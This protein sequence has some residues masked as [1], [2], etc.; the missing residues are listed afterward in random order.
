MFMPRCAALALL[1]C[2]VPEQLQATSIRADG[3]LKMHQITVRGTH[4]SY[5]L[6]PEGNVELRSLYVCQRPLDKQAEF[7]SVRS[8]H[9]DINRRESEGDSFPVFHSVYGGDN[10]TVCDN[11]QQC[12]WILNQWSERSPGHLPIFV[13]INAMDDPLDGNDDLRADWN[14]DLDVEIA[15]VLGPKVYTPLE[16]KTGD[17][18]A[19]YTTINERAAA[20]GWPDLDKL[21]N[22]FVFALTRT[23]DQSAATLNA[24]V[25][26][27]D[28]PRED[29][30]AFVA[31][32]G[33]S[34]KCSGADSTASWAALAHVSFLR[35]DIEG[36]LEETVIS[37]M[38]G[39]NMLVASD[40]CASTDTEYYTRRAICANKTTRA[41]E[42]GVHMP[43]DALLTYTEGSGL[44]AG[45][46]CNLATTNESNCR[47]E[48][49]GVVPASRTDKTVGCD[50]ARCQPATEI[51][52]PNTTECV[53]D[54]AK[55]A[56][57]TGG[58]LTSCTKAVSV[59]P[60]ACVDDDNAYYDVAQASCPLTCGL[61]VPGEAAD[62]ASFGDAEGHAVAAAA[63]AAAADSDGPYGYTDPCVA[64][65]D[66]DPS[67]S[68]P[69]SDGETA[70][71][72][73][74]I[75]VVLVMVV[76]S[77]VYINKRR[78]RNSYGEIES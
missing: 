33:L 76:V 75:V 4:A 54:D 55:I 62:A 35:D 40:V 14:L 12:L 63:A 59:F 50:R 34:G 44:P 27:E 46:I 58:L 31:G 1:L 78:K 65:P 32:C 73:V 70:G 13:W 77:A 71:L 48:A 8:F 49:I 20:E 6:T 69:F 30:M 72:I 29:N 53:D 16:F 67:S 56:E 3:N 25:A 36:S 38:V 61:C 47:S 37:T 68:W 45:A 28:Y 10:R 43:M 39:R 9:L 5:R 15:G 52:V 11:V 57:L 74:A 51:P 60:D 24:T 64:G 41:L 42:L 17:S 21:R 19:S 26:A 23:S 2:S 18:G 7:H 66:P 22:K